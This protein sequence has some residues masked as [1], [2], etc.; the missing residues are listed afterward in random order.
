M[1]KIFVIKY[2][3]EKRETVEPP[4]PFTSCEE[5]FDPLDR[6]KLLQILEKGMYHKR[7]DELYEVFTR[8]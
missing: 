1:D 2:S 7:W 8:T 5:A 6:M 4:L 3:A